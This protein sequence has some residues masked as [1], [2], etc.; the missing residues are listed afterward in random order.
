MLNKMKLISVGIG[1]AGLSACATNNSADYTYYQP[2]NYNAEV[3]NY[4]PTAY[5]STMYTDYYSEKKQ[6]QVPDSYHVGISHSPTSHKNVDSEWVRS[7]N[8]QNYTIELTDGDKASQVA[9]T[10]QKVPKNQRTAEIQY[11]RDGKTYYKGLYGTYPSYEAAQQALGALPA[12]IKD[13]AGVKTWSN[14]QRTVNE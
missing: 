14:V 11:Q 2:Y 10:L 6:V 7:Q 13:K 8:S 4:Y 1:L 5:D 12:D 9:N 3:T